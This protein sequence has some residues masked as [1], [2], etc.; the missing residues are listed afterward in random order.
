MDSQRGF[1][2]VELVIVIVLMSIMSLGSV[3]FIVNIA[4]G[5]A[6][7]SRRQNMVDVTQ[8]SVERISRELRNALPSSVRVSSDGAASC[9]EFIPS[10]GASIY[11]NLPVTTSGTTFNAIPLDSDGALSG[12]STGEPLYVA[13]YPIDSNGSVY[14]LDGNSIVTPLDDTA[15]FVA[16][17]VIDYPENA[18][19]ITVTF[20]SHQFPTESPTGRFYIVGSP[21]SYCLLTGSGNLYRYENYLDTGG[22]FYAAQQLPVTGGLPTTE[23]NR[24]LLSSGISSNASFP[25]PAFAY[26]ETSLQRNALVLFDL[27]VVEDGESVRI[28]HVVQVRNAP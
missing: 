28:Q 19:M 20:A 4:Q 14:T 27:Q 6:D 10:L 25:N 3:Q 2:L 18:S 17:Q 24:A 22:V 5:Y 8:L 13:V 15:Q 9:I 12:R 7:F 21:V 16:D 1:T 23:P 11:Q 26:V